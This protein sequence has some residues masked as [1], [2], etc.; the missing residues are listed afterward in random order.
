MSV[1]KS[2]VDE[3]QKA[4][5]Y[6]LKLSPEQKQVLNGLNSKAYSLKEDYI[7]FT[8]KYYVWN[9]KD[10]N[11]NLLELQNRKYYIALAGLCLTPLRNGINK[12]AV[13][14]S[15]G[16]YAVLSI[17]NP[18]MSK[19][20]PRLVKQSLYPYFDKMSDM[21]PN[22]RFAA[23]L[24]QQK[25]E[26]LIDKNHG[27]L[28]FTP[29]TAALYKLAFIEKAYDD[30]RNNPSEQKAVMEGY[31]EAL[32]TLEELCKKDGVSPHDVSQHMSGVI[33]MR[34]QNDPNYSRYFSE[35]NTPD[36]VLPKAF[37]NGDVNA[38]TG[39]IKI[40]PTKDE[41]GRN[42]YMTDVDGREYSG[43]FSPRPMYT[44]DAYKGQ[45]YDMCKEYVDSIN[46][47]R[48][49]ANYDKF[50]P[51]FEL[52]QRKIQDMFLDD[53]G[54]PQSGE[55]VD[56]ASFKIYSDMAARVCVLEWML[57]D[58]KGTADEASTAEK[59]KARRGLAEAFREQYKKDGTSDKWAEKIKEDD[60]D[61]WLQL[62]LYNSKEQFR[63]YVDPNERTTNQKSWRENREQAT[64]EDNGTKAGPK[65]SSTY[66]SYTAGQEEEYADTYD[67]MGMG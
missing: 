39:E 36:D 59:T 52:K 35:F 1:F 25:Q 40:H 31:T 61:G 14:T 57:D 45:V 42:I 20:I 13:A 46:E 64:K 58:E 3:K 55:A 41:S 15:V 51:S 7:D 50:N 66:S 6:S 49:L 2:Y 32:E 22:S 12:R 48:N 56:D 54:I 21:F 29:E 27:R 16:M 62:A 65:R 9:E 17:M 37:V 44:T 63:Q 11:M 26:I 10:T 30:V 47:A 5:M 19:E 33:A 8:K 24:Q 67:S 4:M 34:I 43:T 38:E 18:T 28:P 23:K 60:Y 53:S